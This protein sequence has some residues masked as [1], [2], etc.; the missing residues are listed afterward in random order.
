MHRSRLAILFLVS[1]F[2][3]GLCRASSFEAR[4]GEEEEISGSCKPILLAVLFL[5]VPA[6]YAARSNSAPLSQQVRQQSD[7]ADAGKAQ[8][9][10]SIVYKNKKYRFRFSL[11]RSWKGYALIV[12][13]WHGSSDQKG[14]EILIRHL[15]WTAANPRQ[16]IQVMVFTLAQWELIDQGEPVVSA[17]PV[18]PGELGRNAKY[19]LAV[20][21][22]YS[23][24]GLLGCDDVIEIMQQNSLHPF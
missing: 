14:P 1:K 18:G 5:V 8:P 19:V 13:Q 20:P 22:R 6:N 23:A 4:H 2:R 15:L 3:N 7:R 10:K 16:D 11:P 9:A 24:A 17:A 12:E 21:P